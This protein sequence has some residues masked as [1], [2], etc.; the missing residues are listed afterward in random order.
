MARKAA[1]RTVR[2]AARKTTRR[3]TRATGR[4]ARRTAR[5]RR[6]ARRV[7]RVARVERRPALFA[8][9]SFRGAI[10]VVKKDG[11]R[12]DF[13]REKIRRG[14]LRAAMRTDVD[15]ARANELAERITSM[16]ERDA[17]DGMRTDEIR[18]ILLRELD[19]EDRRIADSFRTFR[20]GGI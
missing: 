11:S 12:E 7:A 19:R 6:A 1:R 3:T 2:K 17:R 13:D 9:T 10:Q 15:Q 18:D 5:P 4:A 20:E 8:D 14:I 16:I